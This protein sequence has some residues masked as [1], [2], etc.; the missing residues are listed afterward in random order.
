MKD[1]KSQFRSIPKELSA[2]C[3]SSTLC[4][5]LSECVN[6]LFNVC[7]PFHQHQQGENDNKPEFAPRVRIVT[8][9]CSHPVL[10]EFTLLVFV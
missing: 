4:A 6:I 1:S 10:D 2:H 7:I 9:Q 3:L 5:E 8:N